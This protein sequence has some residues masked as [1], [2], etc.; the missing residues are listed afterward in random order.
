MPNINLFCLT[1]RLVKHRIRTKYPRLHVAFA[2]ALIASLVY[3]L[4]R[5]EGPQ[6]AQ[7]APTWKKNLTTKTC[8]APIH[9]IRPIWIILKCTMRFSVFWTVLKLRFSRVRKYFWL[10]EMVDSWPETLKTDSSRLDVCSGE[11]PCLEGS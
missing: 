6:G 4:P 7:G 9:T 8:N 5:L 11:V 1:L 2:S 3:T 10:R